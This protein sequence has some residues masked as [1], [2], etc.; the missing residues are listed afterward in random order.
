MPKGDVVK[1]GEARAVYLPLTTSS[2]GISLHV[3]EIGWTKRLNNV[4]NL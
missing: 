1:G 3:R 4:R 2:V